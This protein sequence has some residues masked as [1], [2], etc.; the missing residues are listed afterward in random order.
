MLGWRAF[1]TLAFAL[2]LITCSHKHVKTTTYNHGTVI[3]I[4]GILGTQ[5]YDQ[6]ARR[7]WPPRIWQAFS[8]GEALVCDAN[9]VPQQSIEVGEPL[10]EHYGKMAETLSEA[11]YR[12]VLFGYDWRLDNT[13]TADRLSTLIGSLG[14]GKV[15]IV[16]HSMG[17]IVA[18][19]YLRAHGLD[20][21]GRLITFGTPFLGA[22]GAVKTLELGDTVEGP[23]WRLVHE[24]FTQVYQN[25]AS[26]YQLL[27]SKLFF[28]FGEKSYLGTA[29]SPAAKEPKKLEGFAR[30]R[31]FIASRPWVN[32][33]LLARAVAFHDQLDLV[34]L[35]AKVDAYFVIGRSQ[36]TIETLTFNLSAKP[37][38]VEAIAYT[39]GNEGDGAVL[40]KSATIGGQTEI[41]H[42]GRT[43]YVDERHGQL[44]NSDRA[45]THVLKI[46]AS[47]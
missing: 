11:G 3:L 20:R 22:P 19:A 24:S 38:E 18:V 7:R 32:Q 26:W 41:I 42:P 5:L 46:L 16:A 4:P 39:H 23:L 43:L 29:A 25:N 15:D 27:P 34:R 8:F 47:H 10:Q 31:D 40:I 6:E 14:P 30:S 21:V 17:G 33:A 28:A 1:A 37:G 45:I 35:L 13:I 36:P 2:A 44:L 12:V 9:G